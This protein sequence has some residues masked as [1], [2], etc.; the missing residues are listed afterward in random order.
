MAG[1]WWSGASSHTLMAADIGD[2][3]VVEARR[4]MHGGGLTHEEVAVRRHG[5]V[6][7]RVARQGRSPNMI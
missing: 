1:G 3:S 2:I 7:G 4:P 5:D 6:D